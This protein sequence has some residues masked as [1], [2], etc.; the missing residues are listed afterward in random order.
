MNSLSRYR[1]TKNKSSRF[2]AEVR[3]SSL[4]GTLTELIQAYGYTLETGAS[5]AHEKG[6]S[7]I[8]RNPKTIEQ[9]VTNLAKAADNAAKNGYSGISYT[10][11]VL[12][13]LVGAPV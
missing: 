10:F 4:E 7:K 12:K 11:E 2:S 3:T 8:N 6:N 13:E 1:I 5:Y 9:L